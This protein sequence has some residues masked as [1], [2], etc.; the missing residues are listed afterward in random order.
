MHSFAPA[1]VYLAA[2]MKYR[3]NVNLSDRIIDGSAQAIMVT[4]FNNRIVRVNPAF[5]RI[6]GYT[7]QEVIGVRGAPLA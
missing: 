2:S 4:D 3:M 1:P 7:A 5:E 6:T